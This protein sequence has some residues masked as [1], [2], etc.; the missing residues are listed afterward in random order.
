MGGAQA[1]AALALGTETIRARRRDRRPGQPLR[2]GGQAPALRPRR[3]RRLR[4][5]VRPARARLAPAPTRA[6]V[7]LDLLAQ[8][9]HG[10]G[11]AR[12]RRCPTTR[13][14]LDAIGREL[15]AL[16]RDAPDGRRRAEGAR[17][18]AA[19]STRALAFAEAL[20]PEH[21]R[22]RRR[23]RRGARPARHAAP[24]ACSSAPRARRRSAT[25]SRVRTT[26]CPTDGAARFASGLHVGALP[27]PHERGARSATPPRRS[28]EA[29]VADRRG[30][31]L[32]RARRVDVRADPPECADRMSRSAAAEP[33]DRRDRRARRARPRRRRAGS[34]SRTGVGFFDH[35]LDLLARHG[36]LGLERDGRGR[37]R[38]R[39]PPHGRGHRD[40]ARPGARRGARRPR[41]GSAATATRS[42]RWT[43][44]APPARSTSPA[45]RTAPSP[46]STLPPGAIA[47]F[48][49]EAAE[50]F[51][52]AVAER[53]AA[54]AAPRAAGRHERAPHDRGVLQ[55]VRPRAARGGVDRPGR[56]RR[57]LDQ[58]D[59]DVTVALVDYGMGNRRSVEKALEHV[60][61]ARRAHR[62]PR[63]RSRAADGDRRCPA[64][65]RSRRRC[66]GCA[67]SGSTG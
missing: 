16:V 44:R 53:R 15:Q 67:R 59:A 11:L 6:L 54:D 13:A 42:C 43:R 9:E 24:A 17:R 19:T 47:G 28:R 49:H 26:R 3:D 8:A 30:R 1:I 48:E 60:G 56:G 7:A 57:A 38:D 36:R 51:F 65:A 31:G 23:G 2:A 37:P 52:R 64:S 21:L 27:P 18:R 40:R 12:R 61:A 39:R 14:L 46:G 62:R 35:M 20:A 4:R 63:A 32:R 55:G 45:G 50:E 22:A 29:G 66:A 58:G 34:R 10:D 33:E 25:T 41:A 5:A